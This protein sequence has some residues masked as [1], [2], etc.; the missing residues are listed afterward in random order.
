MDYEDLKLLLFEAF[1]TGYRA[2]C[3]N[4]HNPMSTFEEYWNALISESNDCPN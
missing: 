3:S 2:G 4:D 1:I